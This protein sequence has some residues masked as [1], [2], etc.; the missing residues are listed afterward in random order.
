MAVVYNLGE[1]VYREHAVAVAHLRA[2]NTQL[3]NKARMM[4]NIILDS[5][6]NTAHVHQS[7]AGHAQYGDKFNKEFAAFKD[8]IIDGSQRNKAA[9]AEKLVKELDTKEN[10]IIDL[11]RASKVKEANDELTATRQLMGHVDRLL[12]ELS[13]I[14]FEDMKRAREDATLT[15][16]NTI[17]VV[18]GVLAG[19]VILA[20]IVGLWIARIISK[21][22]LFLSE[23]VAQIATGDLTVEV[24]AT[25]NDE[26][27]RATNS[28]GNMIAQIRQ[29]IEK[30]QI[31]ADQVAAGSE[32]MLSS[33]QGLSSGSQ[34]QASSLEETTASL[35][36]I[37]SA[38]KQNADNADQANHL[39]VAARDVAEKGGQVVGSAVCAMSD[40]NQASRK[41][42]DIITAIDDIAFQTNLLALNAA[43]EAAR[44][45]E[46]GRGFAVVAAEVRNLAQRSAAAAKEIKGLIQDSVRKVEAGSDLVSKSGQTLAEIVASVRRVTDLMAEIAATSKE[47]STGITQVNRAVAQMD[48]VVQRNAAQAEEL[49][50][51]A[52]ALTQQA[53][54]LQ[55]IVGRFKLGDGPAH[56][57]VDLGRA[58]PLA[59]LAPKAAVLPKLQ[60]K[61]ASN[62]N[63]LAARPKAQPELAKH[64]NPTSHRLSEISGNGTHSNGKDGFEEY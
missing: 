24:K 31:S 37:T 44:A 12:D 14:T 9:E 32:Q 43:V 39:A 26:V 58:R 63:A 2:A 33:S 35:E 30:I 45:G 57:P 60:I 21:P 16:Q 59:A 61:D 29:L 36:E 11:A 55:D 5:N 28:I 54:D 40:I 64:M 51:A 4:R 3:A 42:V 8:G 25:P 18:A 15:Y 23:S 20:F 52:Q 19:A 47:Q 7:A 62:G 17:V 38:V 1:Q 41:I 46:Q 50:A 22:L 13:A 6:F 48:S 53:V 34:E 49:S 56:A 27:G 10:Q